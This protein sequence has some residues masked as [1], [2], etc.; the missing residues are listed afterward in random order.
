MIK[1]AKCLKDK[2]MEEI[3][4]YIFSSSFSGSTFTLSM[5]GNLFQ[6]K[7][8][9]EDKTD[10]INY[11]TLPLRILQQRS[12][13]IEEL[14]TTKHS[15]LFEDAFASGDEKVANMMQIFKKGHRVLTPTKN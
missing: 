1:K 3:L 10:K 12:K 9:I 15:P 4:S 6:I 11:I 2:A 7:L 8:L 5:L 13:G 14:L